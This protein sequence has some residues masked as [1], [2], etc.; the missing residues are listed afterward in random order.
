M[1]S[2]SAP[3]YSFDLRV[4]GKPGVY[5]V[6]VDAMTGAVGSVEHEGVGEGELGGGR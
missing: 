6:H 5:E 2:V 4:D 1:V 3:L